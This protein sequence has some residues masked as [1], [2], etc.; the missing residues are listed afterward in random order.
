[1]K[2]RGY[3]VFLTNADLEKGK[4]IVNSKIKPDKIFS[5]NK[6]LIRMNIGKVKNAIHE[7]VIGS[8]SEIIRLPSH[9]TG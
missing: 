8:T 4:L 7:K 3:S 9:S 6:R 2:I 1:L 5:A